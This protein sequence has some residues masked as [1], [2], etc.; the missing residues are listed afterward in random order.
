MIFFVLF[1]LLKKSCIYFREKQEYRLKWKIYKVNLFTKIASTSNIITLVFLHPD[2]SG[3]LSELVSLLK[4]KFIPSWGRFS[5]GW[6][7]FCLWGRSGGQ[8]EQIFVHRLFFFK[9]YLN[10]WEFTLLIL[11]LDSTCVSHSFSLLIH[12]RLFSMSQRE[13]LGKGQFCSVFT[14]VFLCSLTPPE[15][16]F[17]G[18]NTSSQRVLLSVILSFCQGSS[19][20]WAG[21]TAPS[22]LLHPSMLD[23]THMSIF[24]L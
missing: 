2:V 15:S 23:N 3:H 12:S 24:C 17:L 4:K 16:P 1:S 9:H 22:S 10:S 11:L 18:N 21:K 7:L 20:I 6:A 14:M 13:L 19:Q 5:C 8:S